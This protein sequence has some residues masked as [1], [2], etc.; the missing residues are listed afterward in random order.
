MTARPTKEELEESGAA[1]KQRRG[2]MRSKGSEERAPT[3][4]KEER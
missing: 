2:Q 4:G 3:H 1:K